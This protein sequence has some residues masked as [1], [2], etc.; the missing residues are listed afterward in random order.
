M[1]DRE[2]FVYLAISPEHPDRIRVAHAC[3]CGHAD[4]DGWHIA[5]TQ[6]VRHPQTVERLLHDHLETLGG[7]N[8]GAKEFTAPYSHAHMVLTTLARDFAAE[9]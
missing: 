4:R 2:G 7:G 5:H 3:D 6:R 8:R 9:G 1:Q